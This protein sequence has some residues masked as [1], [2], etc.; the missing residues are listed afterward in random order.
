MKDKEM[1]FAKKYEK[2]IVVRLDKASKLFINDN[3]TDFDILTKTLG[4]FL[5][6]SVDTL[7]S[8]TLES[9]RETPYKDFSKTLEIIQ[10]Q[11]Q[12]ARDK[13]SQAQYNEKFDSLTDDQKEVIRT[14]LPIKINVTDPK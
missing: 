12:M 9:S 2:K 11:F 4:N 7:K 6:P 5:T 8:V 3:Q 1:S 13:I 14:L 10:G